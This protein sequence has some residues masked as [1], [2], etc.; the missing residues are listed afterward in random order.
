MS[1]PKKSLQQL[2]PLRLDIPILIVL[3]AIL[4]YNGF[5]MPV[6]TVRKLW[7]RT[8]FSILTG[9]DNL[10]QE[11]FYFLA[12]IIF[13]FSI[14]FPVTKLLS[15]FLVWF[16]KLTDNQRKNILYYLEILGRWSMLD[17]FVAAVLVVSVKLGALAEANAEVGIYY[18]AASILLAMTATTL[19]NRLARSV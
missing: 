9:I 19:Q 4:L 8:T 7:E 18:F 15:L 11:K 5:N 1:D 10:W 12:I 16:I 17:V 13:T 14:I 2:H 3:S 6:L